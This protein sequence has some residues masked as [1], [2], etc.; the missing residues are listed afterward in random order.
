MLNWLGV[1]TLC[2]SLLMLIAEQNGFVKD[3]YASMFQGLGF[4]PFF[5]LIISTYKKYN[6]FI[7]THVYQIIYFF[8]MLLSSF[9]LSFGVPMIEIGEVGT[10]NG[11]FWL[12]MIYFIIGMIFTNLGFN[13]GEK[14]IYFQNNAKF[15]PKVEKFIIL[16]TLLI[17]LIFSILI[18][19]RYGVPE[20]SSERTIYWGQ[21]VPKNLAWVNSA[22]KQ[23]FFF[24]SLAVIFPIYKS[25]KLSKFMLVAYILTTVYVLGEKASAFIILLSA[26][27][28]VYASKKY[29]KVNLKLIFLILVFVVLILSMVIASYRQSGYGD[30]FVLTRIALQAQVLWATLNMPSFPFYRVEDF[31]NI[32]NIFAIPDYMTFKFLPRNLYELYN[33]TGSTISGFFPAFQ[34]LYFGIWGSLVIQI[35]ASILLGFVAGMSLAA[36]RAKSYILSYLIFKIYFAFVFALFALILGSVF[37][38]VFIST[39]LLVIL[40]Y[41]LSIHDRRA[42]L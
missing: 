32:P 6:S 37:S 15:S 28:F 25:N 18:V 22:V 42:S 13:Y 26:F 14:T 41:V 5:A 35:F 9:L 8:G 20:A 33:E 31:A 23:V 27:M 3:S 19:I 1:M 40:I 11:V 30:L 16:L 17:P 2:L 7:L 29:L 21:V 4:L 10:A 12:L 38:F 34:L 36:I 39:I 24:V